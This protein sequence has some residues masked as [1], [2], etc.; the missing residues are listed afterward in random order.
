M[1]S[2]DS[3]VAGFACCVGVYVVFGGESLNWKVFASFSG[4]IFSDLFLKMVRDRVC[5]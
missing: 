3:A 5:L 2:M 4:N 1:V